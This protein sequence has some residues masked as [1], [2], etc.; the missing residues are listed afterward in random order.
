MTTA[1]KEIPGLRD[2]HDLREK[3]VL[4][5]PAATRPLLKKPS[6][7]KADTEMHLYIPKVNIYTSREVATNIGF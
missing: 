2:I 4:F 6:F 3:R 5:D 7:D 1:K